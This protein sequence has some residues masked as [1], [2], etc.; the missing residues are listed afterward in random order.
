[1]LK[2]IENRHLASKGAVA[3]L[4]A[5]LHPIPFFVL[6]T[7]CVDFPWFF[8]VFDDEIGVLPDIGKLAGRVTILSR[9]VGRTMN[10]SC[11]TKCSHR[12]QAVYPMILCF[13]SS[14]SG[15]WAKSNGVEIGLSLP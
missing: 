6:P 3:L 15:T 2:G 5:V 10:R 14:C 11:H 13:E 1:M 12:G 9:R 8:S 4:H 7:N